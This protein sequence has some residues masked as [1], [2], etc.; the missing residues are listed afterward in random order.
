MDRQT[1]IPPS[2]VRRIQMLT[3]RLMNSSAPV[4][5]HPFSRGRRLAPDFRA[6]FPSA[7]DLARAKCCTE[8]AIYTN[9]CPGEPSKHFRVQCSTL[10]IPQAQTPFHPPLPTMNDKR[11]TKGWDQILQKQ[12]QREIRRYCTTS[13]KATAPPVRP[14]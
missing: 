2:R 5:S 11:H 6:D 3:P 9:A 4:C 1:T 14:P 8:C 10:Q 7:F 13:S 12:R